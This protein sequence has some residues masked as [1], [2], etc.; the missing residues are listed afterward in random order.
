MTPSKGKKKGVKNSQ[1]ASR[2]KSAKTASKRYQ[3]SADRKAYGNDD[4]L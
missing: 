4:F 2:P 3:K 1:S